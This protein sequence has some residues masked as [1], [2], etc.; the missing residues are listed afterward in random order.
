[1]RLVSLLRWSQSE[2]AARIGSGMQA[3][4]ALFHRPTVE[5]GSGQIWP[6]LEVRAARKLQPAQT[7]CTNAGTRFRQIPVRRAGGREGRPSFPKKRRKRLSRLSTKRHARKGWGAS[8]PPDPGA[9]L[10]LPKVT[11]VYGDGN[12][13]P[14]KVLTRCCR[15]GFFSRAAAGQPG[16]QGRRHKHLKNPKSFASFLQKRRPCFLSP[17]H[18]VRGML[19][20]PDPPVPLG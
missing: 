7:L 10:Y 2:S 17:R 19:V 4:V 15:G 3:V 20:P 1:M 18:T 14:K 5:G 8:R 11:L 9:N 6:Y 16:A 13:V 12:R